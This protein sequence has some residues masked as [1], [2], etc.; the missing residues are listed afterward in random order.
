MP[1]KAWK[2][3]ER[4]IG[5]LFGGERVKRMGDF[6][7]SAT[8][9]LLDDLKHFRIDC[10]LRQK[11]MHHSLYDEIQ[12]K[13]CKSDEDVA[14][15]VTKEYGRY[16]YL[17]SVDAEFFAVLLEAYRDKLKAGNGNVTGIRSA[18]PA[19]AR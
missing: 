11:F 8:D 10:K 18:P 5:K 12:K 4:K 14:V 6:S 7:V 9:V 15:M 1:D 17:V 13:Y 3:L 16:R 19:S 2:R